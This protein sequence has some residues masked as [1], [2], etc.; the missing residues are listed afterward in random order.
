MFPYSLRLIPNDPV[1]D[2]P[3]LDSSGRSAFAAL[4][5]DVLERFDGLFDVAI[6]YMLWIHQRP[7]DGGEWPGARL[8]AEIVS[9]WRARGVT[10]YIAAGE[11]GSGIYFNPIAAEDAARSLREAV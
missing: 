11:V 4:L 5:V 8:H 6:P 3:S 2:L 10:R 7:F 9:P 1:P